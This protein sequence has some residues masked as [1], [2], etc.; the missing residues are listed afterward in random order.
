LQFSVLGLGT[1]KLGRNTDVKYPTAFA[2]PSDEAILDLLD[3]A[4]KLGINYLDTAPAYGSA[5]SRLG[6]LLPHSPHHFQLVSKAGE[7]YDP[8]SG[9]HFDFSEKG[10]RASIDQSL[11]NLGRDRLE[12]VL[13]HSDGQDI[14]RLDE[15]ALRTLISCR[16]QGLIRAVGLSSKTLEGG[17]RA[18]AEGANALMIT[19]NADTQDDAPLIAEAAACGAGILIKK[20]LGS[21][22]LASRLDPPA[23]LAT[24]LANSQITSAVIGTLNPHHL[25]HNC[26]SLLSGESL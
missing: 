19:L 6:Q 12:L 26:D 5:E 23:Q 22:H 2:L 1:V 16:D 24:L 13:L 11:R 10:L 4:G 8:T 20:A 18:L 17:R 25:R 15:G 21:G 3:T 14:E 7:H 9:S